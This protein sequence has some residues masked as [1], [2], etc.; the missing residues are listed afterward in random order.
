MNEKISKAFGGFTV[1]LIA[2]GSSIYR[3]IHGNAAGE[4][5]EKGNLGNGI[6]S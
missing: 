6:R 4:I 3:F 2:G 5:T 1:A